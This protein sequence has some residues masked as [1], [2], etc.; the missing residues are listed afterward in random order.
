MIVWRD[1]MSIDS[2]GV[3]DQ[4]HKHLI[5]IINRFEELA[6]DGLDREEASEVLYALKFYTQTHFGREE[7]LQN[8]VRFPY[9]DAHHHEHR[10]L[11]EQLEGLI[12]E[13]H[14]SDEEDLGKVYREIARMLHDWLVNHILQSD[15]KMTMYVE[16]MNKFDPQMGALKD[17]KYDPANIE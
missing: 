12:L 9:A 3:I 8:L 6:G 2:G 4:D 10:A 7:Q 5:D 17:L 15:L 14:E 11:I 1:K 16:A 13:I